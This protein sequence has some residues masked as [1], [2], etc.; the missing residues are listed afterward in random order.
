VRLGVGVGWQASEYESLGVPFAERGARM[1]ECIRLLR[2]YWTEPSV[3]FRGRY[4]RAEAMGMDPKPV[5]PGGPPIWVG[6]SSP[7]AVRRAA[8][9]GDGWLPQ[10]PIDRAVVDRIRQL[11]ADAGLPEAF[12][13]GALVGSVYVGDPS[14]DLGGPA[15]TGPPE[16]VAEGLAW[17]SDLGV[18]Q[19]Q[20]RLRSRSVTELVDQIEAFG[21]QVAPLVAT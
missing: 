5:Q 3:T 15:L 10:G 7:A 11:R 8:T 16:K 17:L 9:R 13:L 1:D 19:G 20:V 2:L 14:W 4:Y 21:T 12:D 6:G 18:G